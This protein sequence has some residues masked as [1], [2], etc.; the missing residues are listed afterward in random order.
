MTQALRMRRRFRAASLVIALAWTLAGASTAT[1]Q[2]QFFVLRDD[3][4]LFRHNTSL[5]SAVIDD[6]PIAGMKE[7]NEFIEGIDFR[8][9]D[10]LLYGV[11]TKN[12]LYRIDPVSGVATQMGT[13][14]FAISFTEKHGLDFNPAADRL[15]VLDGPTRNIRFNPDTAAQIVDTPLAYAAGDANAGQPVN[16]NAIAYTNNAPGVATTTLLGIDHALDVLVRIGGVDGN[17]SPNGGEVTTIG[18]L[19]VD[20]DADTQ[21]DVGPNNTALALI[22]VAGNPTLFAI[23]QATG[24]AGLLGVTALA[25]TQTGLAIAPVGQFEFNAASEVISE[26]AGVATVTVLRKAGAFGEVTVNFTTANGTATEPGDYTAT[27]G[28]LTFDVDETSKSITIPIIDDTADEADETLTVT[29]SSPGGGAT[30][31]TLITTTVTIVDNDSPPSLIPG[32]NCGAGACG[33]GML[34]ALPMGLLALGY[35]RG[36]SRR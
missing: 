19:G 11:S 27:S 32:L 2:F 5:P 3:N 26:G 4:T 7:V 30:L 31:G 21:L 1:A 25:A 28:T 8:P 17:P 14:T 23:N 18:A 22:H 10:G 24:A 9:A 35:R 20:A 34:S 13:G 33:A 6:I 36:R 12:R 29:I 15:R 16:I